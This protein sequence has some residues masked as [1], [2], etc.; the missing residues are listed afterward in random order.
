M[1]KTNGRGIIAQCSTCNGAITGFTAIRSISGGGYNFVLYQCQNCGTGALAKKDD[2]GCLYD[3]Y[4]HEKNT[5]PLPIETPKDILS[6]F[7]SAENCASIGEYRPASAMLRSTLEKVLK[8]NGYTKEITKE[9][10]V[11]NDLYNLIEL[12]S[13]DGI[14]TE[15]RKVRAQNEVRVL[16]NDILHEDWFAVT[17]EDYSRAHYYTQ[18]VIEDLYDDRSMVVKTLQEKGRIKSELDKNNKTIPEEK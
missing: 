8:A 15:S 14:I 17:E 11:K 4:P 13:K 16:G 1:A 18:R 10:G 2:Y 5:L 3:F 9:V 7:T 6:E 12:A